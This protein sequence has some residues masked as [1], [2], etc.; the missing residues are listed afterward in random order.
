MRARPLRGNLLALG[1]FSLL[2]A[3]AQSPENPSFR[4][5]VDLVQVDAVVNDSK[6]NHIRDLGA[7]DFQVTEDGK[8]QK[9]T[10]FSWI[11]ARP[12]PA[13]RTGLLSPARNLRKDEIRRS[14][15]LMVDDSGRHAEE[16][17]LPLL[18]SMK[19]FVTEQ[20]GPGDLAAVTASRGGMGFYQQFT[21][22]KQ[23]LQEAID[24]LAHRPG[25]GTWT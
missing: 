11:D 15:V 7:D 2:P 9:I 23:Q 6:G 13:A 25:F 19:R 17:L 12:D 5:S 22:D 18:G 21:N 3:A 1:I 20:L 16:D 10:N 14:L 24:R 8:P 4:I